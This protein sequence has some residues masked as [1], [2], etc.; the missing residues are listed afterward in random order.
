MATDLKTL[1]KEVYSTPLDCRILMMDAIEKLTHADTLLLNDS[2]IDMFALRARGI[3][4]MKIGSTFSG[5]SVIETTPYTGP[6]LIP[7]PDHDN[8]GENT[9]TG[10]LYGCVPAS[11][12][13]TELWTILFT[14]DTAF[15]VTGSFSGSQGTGSISSDF[16][17]TNSDIVIPSDAWA[18]TPASGDYFYIPVY[19]HVPEIVA[20]SS[21]LT[22]GLVLKGINASTST[23]G[24][25]I[26]TKFYNDAESLLDDIASGVSGLM[27]VNTLLNS[28]DLMISYEI[29][30]AGYDISNYS[31][32]EYNRFINNTSASY[33][34][35]QNWVR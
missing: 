1:R 2:M 15:S 29:S 16:T 11:D 4:D 9:G 8:I 27:G 35:W 28:S 24:A 12:A 17:S 13:F 34:F 26:G 23:E 10:V 5:S 19:K 21:L 33:P 25:G 20:L 6:V 14:S 30:H 18:G 3:I 7:R 22:A 32:D 31:D